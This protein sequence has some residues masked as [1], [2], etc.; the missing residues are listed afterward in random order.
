M[1]VPVRK[2]FWRLGKG[3]ARIPVHVFMTAAGSRREESGGAATL[4]VVLM[5]P[6]A[7]FA[8]SVAQAGPQRLAAE[9]S[10][11][12]A[13]EDLATLAV[14]WRDAQ[15]ASVGELTGFPLDCTAS[16]ADEAMVAALVNA[17]DAQA[18]LAKRA[19]IA[20]FI[21]E[22]DKFHDIVV[23]DLG[24]L[25]LDVNSLRG[26]Y[27]DSLDLVAPV[28]CSWSPTVEVRDAVHVALAA[29]WKDAGW[30]AAQVWPD[31]LQMGS[32]SIGRLERNL[33]PGSGDISGNCSPESLEPV[34]ASGQARWLSGEKSSR[35]LT[36]SAPSRTTFGRDA[37]GQ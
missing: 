8:A 23:R 1:K 16:S 24:G 4:W 5:V 7:A 13:T 36:E 11:K 25:G 32:E 21:A 33:A 2:R 26:F 6:I 34:D 18:A 28:P 15:D 30:A 37:W 10:L 27:S 31:G 20:N 17:G 19:Q 12:E 29:D 9:S 3:L 35:A 22:C 14:A